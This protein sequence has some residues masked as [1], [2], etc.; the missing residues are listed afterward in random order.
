MS[1]KK[2]GIFGK[3]RFQLLSS[4]HTIVLKI[5]YGISDFSNMPLEG[6][7]Y[8]DRTNYI[9]Q[10]E[11][12]GRKTVHYVRP[13]R[14]G[15]SLFLSM[16]HHYYGQEYKD[17]FQELFGQYYIGQHPTKRAN[18]YLVL[19]FDFSGIDTKT[20]KSTYRDFTDNVR[21]GIL[22]FLAAY[23]QFF[24]REDIRLI[25]KIDSPQGLLKELFT[26]IRLKTKGQKLYVLVDEYDHFTNELLSADF[27]LFM[28]IASNNGWVRK[29]YEVL[30][31]GNSI[32]IVDRIFLTG[33]SPVTLDSLTS[34]YNI[35]TNLST[36]LHYCEMMGFTEEEVVTMLQ[37]VSVPASQLEEVLADLRFWYNGY[38]FNE[39]GRHRIYNPDMVLYFAKYYSMYQKYPKDL[40]DENI[41]SDYGKMERLFYVNDSGPMNIQVLKKILNEGTVTAVLTKKYSFEVPWTKDHFVSLLYYLGILTI[42]GSDELDE[43]VFQMPNFVIRQLYYKFF[44]RLILQEAQ[45]MPAVVDVGAKIKALAQKNNWHPLLQLI[46]DI[47]A[48]LGREDKAHFNE[49][50][51][52]T[53]FASFFYQVAYYNIYSELEVRKAANQKGRVD[54]LLTRRP[55]F[56][57]KYQFVFELKYLKTK[58]Q[59]SFER[60]KKE[61]ITQLSAYLQM[62]DAL[63]TLD[64]LKAYVLIFVGNEGHIFE[65][66]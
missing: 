8:V 22:S 38:L 64:H 30:K 11:N 12:S 15:K 24:N 7:F 66:T 13:R 60:I 26:L 51:L 18:S 54:L 52:K 57:P 31:R 49:V 33:V 29:F 45:M 4:N 16:L 37:G 3:R 46:T 14:F 65:V 35:S 1:Q 47:I 42:E 2:T 17:Q 36:E 9:E 53:L 56:N 21:K 43:L 25:R 19:S 5:P 58:Q 55:P 20:S 62:D 61:A 28:K 44:N 34:G 27:S 23:S 10:L 50:S 63:N 59:A 48:Q 40:L 6:Y 41:A 39:S 32:G